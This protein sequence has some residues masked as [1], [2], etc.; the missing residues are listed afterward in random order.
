MCVR[1]LARLSKRFLIEKK[2]HSEWPPENII[3][4]FLVFYRFYV[5][6]TYGTAW[7]PVLFVHESSCP[8]DNPQWLVLLSCNICRDPQYEF[9]KH[10]KN[11]E[12]N[13]NI[14][15]TSILQYRPSIWHYCLCKKLKTNYKII[16]W[17]KNTDSLK[18]DAW[19]RGG[20][21]KWAKKKYHEIK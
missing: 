17:N 7:F 11:E 9:A 21:Q 19:S 20:G 12:P 1:F 15:S 8:M 6:L 3:A 2:C 18:K 16:L 5:K 4:L 14:Y 10:S 13:W